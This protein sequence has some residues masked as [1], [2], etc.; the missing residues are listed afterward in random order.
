MTLSITK[1]VVMFFLKKRN[2]AESNDFGWWLTG[3]DPDPDPDDVISTGEEPACKPSSIS[4]TPERLVRNH[5]YSIV[6]SSSTSLTEVSPPGGNSPIKRFSNRRYRRL[7]RFIDK[8]L[9]GASQLEALLDPE[10]FDVRIPVVYRRNGFLKESKSYGDI[11]TMANTESP[12][13]LMTPDFMSSGSSCERII[14]WKCDEGFLAERTNQ[15]AVGNLQWEGH[16]REEIF[17]EMVYLPET[18]QEDPE[19]VVRNLRGRIEHIKEINKDIFEDVSSLRKNFQ[20]YRT[21]SR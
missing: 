21:L 3:T 7:S 8:K 18:H 2:G 16:N 4:Y 1:I 5:D 6:S 20:V 17:S 9:V 10:A 11:L 19:I 12:Q 14:N 15:C 13:R